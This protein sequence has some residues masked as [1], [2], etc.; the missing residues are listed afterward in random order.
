A[1]LFGI[2]V[3]GV[4]HRPQHV[5]DLLEVPR[6]AHRH[7]VLLDPGLCR[8]GRDALGNPTAA[9][10]VRGPSQHDEPADPQLAV[11]SPPLLGTPA[12]PAVVA[13]GA[14]ELG[15]EEADDRDPARVIH[16]A[17]FLSHWRTDSRS[18]AHQAWV[19]LARNIGFIE[20]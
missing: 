5:E 9:L 10:A 18:W 12:T 17:N 15:A 2:E 20:T 1:V 7:R 13:T 16:M 6:V 19:R 11:H 8:A 14:I 3:E 4:G